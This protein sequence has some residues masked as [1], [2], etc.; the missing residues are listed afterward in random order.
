ME[1]FIK[2][3]PYISSMITGIAAA[4]LTFLASEHSTKA[5]REEAKDKALDEHKAQLGVLKAEINTRID[6]LEEKHDENMSQLYQMVSEVKATVQESNAIVELKLENLE[7][8]QDKHNQLIDRMYNAEKQ[9]GILQER[10]A[11]A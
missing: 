5:K 2:V 9:I 10:M 11:H 8:K 7:E 4:I 1:T 3:F 6:A